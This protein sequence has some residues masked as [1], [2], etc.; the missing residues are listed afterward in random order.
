MINNIINKYDLYEGA[1][2]LV[3]YESQYN[4]DIIDY[5]EESSNFEG[6]AT[7]FNIDFDE[8]VF[9]IEDMEEYP[10]S[11]DYLIVLNICTNEYEYIT[12]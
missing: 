2:I 6:Y 1:E 9:Y 10:M 5:F 4:I 3:D 7:L 8:G 11:I 12:F